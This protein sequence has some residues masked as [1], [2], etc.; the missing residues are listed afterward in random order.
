MQKTLLFT[1]VILA[2]SCKTKVDD[3][4]INVTS[5]KVISFDTLLIERL[6]VFNIETSYTGFFSI[7]ND[8]LHYIDRRFGWV[9]TLDTAGKLINQNLGQGEGPWELNTAY[10]DGYATLKSGDHFFIGSS[11]DIHIHDKLYKRKSEY[12]LGWLGN[13]DIDKVRES[14]LPDPNEFSL[15]TLD[16]ENL[17]LRTDARDNLYIPIYCENRRFNAFSSARYYNEGRILAQ[18]NLRT[19]KVEQ[20]LGK[21]SAEYLKFKYLG[22]HASFSFDIDDHNNF[23]VSHEIDSIIYKFD[24]NF[25]LIKKFGFAGKAMDQNYKQVPEFDLRL[26]RDA[27]GNDRP[28]RGY[29]HHI[30]YFDQQ[31]ILFRSYTKGEHTPVDGLQVYKEGALIADVN[32]PKGLVIRGFINPYFYCE[33]ILQNDESLFF[34]RFKLPK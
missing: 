9:F 4:I 23:Y 8:S 17:T 21:R 2:F 11:F 13:Q 7:F 18:L 34:Y 24:E 25:H 20:L 29:Y 3:K 27:Y 28:K 16:Y 26:L 33:S 5:K 10:I 15:Y 19:G 31:D 22:H 30:E 12:L 6:E 1:F 14:E 32:V